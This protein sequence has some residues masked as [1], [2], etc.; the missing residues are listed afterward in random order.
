MKKKKKPRSLGYMNLTTDKKGKLKLNIKPNLANA[1][2]IL[3]NN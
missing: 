1:L 2:Q 3:L